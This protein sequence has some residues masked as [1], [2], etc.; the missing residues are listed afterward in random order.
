M[1]WNKILTV[2]RRVGLFL[3]PLA[4]LVGLSAAFEGSAGVAALAK[5]HLLYVIAIVANLGIGVLLATLQ[6]GESANKDKL[7][8]KE[9]LRAYW[10][11]LIAM[12]AL[13]PCASALIAVVIYLAEWAGPEGRH[14]LFWGSAIAVWAWFV[15][16]FA[17]RW[18]AEAEHAIPSSYLE[19]CQR[20][21][22]LKVVREEMAPNNPK[23]TIAFKEVE[24]QEKAIEN[25]LRMPGLP[26]VLARGYDNVWDRLYRAEEALIEVAPE[27]TV[28]AGAL[29]DELRLQDSKIDNCG[30]LLNKLRQAVCV[31]DPRTKQYLKSSSA[32]TT[33]LAFGTTSP[34]REVTVGEKYDQPLL[35]M[36]GTPPYTWTITGGEKPSGLELD[37]KTG[38]LSG[39]PTEAKTFSFT[40]RVTDSAKEM[41]EKPLK[42]TVKPFVSHTVT[43]PLAINTTSPLPEGTV[44]TP[45][46]QPLLAAGGTPP[47]SWSITGGEKP[48][49]L[50]L[51]QKT[52]V[53]SGKPTDFKTF[54]FT[55]EVTDKGGQKNEIFL[56]LAINPNAKPSPAPPDCAEPKTVARAVLRT[57]R[58]S[59]N[60]YRGERWNGLIVA[61]NRLLATM[62]FTALMAYALLVI[63]LIGNA[64]KPAIV[65]ASTFYLVGATIGLLGRLRGE[66]QTEAAFED[67]GLSAARLITIP[68]LSGLAA[69]GGVVLMAMMPLASTVFGPTSPA[70]LAI[71]TTTL[72]PE[73]TVGKDYDQTLRAAGG[74]PPYTWTVAVGTVPPGIVLNEKTGVLSGKPT[75]VGS[76][77]F[78][79]QVADSAGAPGKREFTLVIQSGQSKPAPAAGA[80]TKSPDK[81]VSVPQQGK[82]SPEASDSPETNPLVLPPVPSLSKIFDLGN[83][84]IGLLV[85]ALFGLT[86]GLLFDR[87]QQLTEKYK[88]DLKSS[89]ATQGAQKT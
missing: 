32:V 34:L 29:Y 4:C 51:D 14:A 21:T 62:F 75:E 60:E 79:V 65:A 30:D 20:L 84:L 49:G 86:P 41:M 17:C 85:A 53:L 81:L 72:L 22:Q 70:P 45:Y 33:L 16:A 38:M 6:Q 69:I 48:P 78:T 12:V 24:E 56:T 3:L 44:N 71:S 74:K 68:L 10:A 73:G 83:N 40:V 46:N 18:L 59:I 82:P 11:T 27:E 26:W 50:E 77:K 63:A 52:G 13:L 80:S 25:E 58:R 31:I 43:T 9:E 47:Y 55:V 2:V 61:R 36:G 42:L 66:S 89:Q 5:G 28:V 7:T 8:N 15:A 37:Q 39:N 35:A 23:K 88:S 87:L 76:S 67:Y 1:D 57:V 19:L 64:P 54:S